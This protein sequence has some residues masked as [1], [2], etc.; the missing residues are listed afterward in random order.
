MEWGDGFVFGL[1]ALAQEV[2]PLL[3][4]RSLELSLVGAPEICHGATEIHRVR[5][6]E[7]QVLTTLQLALASRIDVVP[8]Q[9]NLPRAHVLTR[10]ALIRLKLL[11]LQTE[12]KLIRL[13]LLRLPTY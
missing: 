9:L 13:K 12:M 8:D 3:H 7:L 1:R 11:R 4:R 2:R 10:I 5:L 6:A